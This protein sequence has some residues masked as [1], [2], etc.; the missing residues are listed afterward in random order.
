VSSHIRWA[1][2]NTNPLP[3][4]LGTTFDV[5]NT[6]GTVDYSGVAHDTGAGWDK[7]HYDDSP[8]DWIDIGVPPIP[9]KHKHRNANKWVQQW[10][11]V[12]I[13]QEKCEDAAHK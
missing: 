10:R 8:E 9:R 6:D 13:C 5:L 1:V 12:P 2:A 7:D 4:R 3:Y 11:N